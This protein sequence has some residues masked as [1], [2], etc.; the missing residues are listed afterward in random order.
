MISLKL[1][2]IAAIAGA[3]LAAAAI[4]GVWMHGD[5]HGALKCQHATSQAVSRID[6]EVRET[7]R[8]RYGELLDALNTQYMAQRGIADTLAADVERLRSRPV[9]ADRVPGDPAATCKG[10]SGAELA[11]EHAGFLVRYAARAA[12]QDAAL[13][14]CYDAYDAVRGLGR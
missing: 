9:R 3:T 7:E 4:T 6:A 14:A 5:S 2:L 8:K 12:E 11:R 10:A 1:K 13:A